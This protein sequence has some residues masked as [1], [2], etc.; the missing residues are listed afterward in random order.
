MQFDRY[1]ARYREGLDLVLKG[2]SCDIR[3]GEKVSRT[4]GED[5]GVAIMLTVFSV[6]CGELHCNEVRLY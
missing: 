3:G 5:E 1:S 2:I 6:F 4:G